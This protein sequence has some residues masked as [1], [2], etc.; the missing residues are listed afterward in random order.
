MFSDH[1]RMKFEINGN[2]RYF[3]KPSNVWKLNNTSTNPWSKK[4]SHGKLENT[5]N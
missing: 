3:K 2:G 1:K 5:L 4:K